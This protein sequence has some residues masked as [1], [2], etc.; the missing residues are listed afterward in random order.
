MSLAELEITVERIGARGDGIASLASGEMLYIP[1]SAPGDRLIVSVG[2]KRGNGRMGITRKVVEAANCRT[3][4]SCRHFSECGGCS[5][6]HL[7]KQSIADLKRRTLMN[8]LQRRG[9]DTDTVEATVTIPPGKRRRAEFA[10]SGSE[11]STIGLHAARGQKVVDLQECHVVVPEIL[12][13]LPKLRALV[14]A[15]GLGFIARDIRITKTDSGIDILLIAKNGQEPELECRQKLAEFAETHDLARVA[16]ADLDRTE[17]LALRRRPR[18][19]LGDA[20]VD[21]PEQYFLQPSIEG[22]RTIANLARRGIIDAKNIADLYAGLGCLSFPMAE[23]SKVRAFEL[24]SAM[25][26]ASTRAA[27]GLSLTAER[28]DLARSPLTE[29]ELNQFDAIIFDPPSAGARNQASYLAR[30]AVQMIVAVSC[31]PNTLARD[32]R[33]LFDGGYCIQRITPVDQF[34][35]SAE[36]EAVAV[37]YR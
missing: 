1:F 5:L 15:T 4:P 22:E 19:K 24:D 18:L 35:W 25:V 27:S 26:A 3:E 11:S 8:A 16:W 29:R 12:E 21:L 30:S 9:L 32:L 7:K 10:L 33:I 34:T 31:N 20:I 2:E 36:L 23:Q 17:P 13:L 14:H 6:Q 28:R 37:L